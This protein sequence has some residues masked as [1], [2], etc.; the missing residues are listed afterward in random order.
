MIDTG[1]EIWMLKRR[2]TYIITSLAVLVLI[3]AGVVFFHWRGYNSAASSTQDN[4]P[5]VKLGFSYLP[6]NRTVAQYYNLGVDSGALVT[7]VT[8]GGLAEQAGIVPGDVVTC[9]N[10][11]Q[12]TADTSLLGLMQSCNVTNGVTVEFT[13]NGCCRLVNIASSDPLIITH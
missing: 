13:S 3:A 4:S 9:F 12:I 8:R 5:A 7:G 10:G 6:V 11:C 2:S 1:G